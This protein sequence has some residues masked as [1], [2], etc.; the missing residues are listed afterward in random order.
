MRLLC[1][2]DTRG[3]PATG[4]SQGTSTY[5]TPVEKIR[6]SEY[7]LL[8]GLCPSMHTKERPNTDNF[9]KQHTSIMQEQL[10]SLSPP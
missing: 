1:A 5:P 8:E 9:Q 4:L 10:R 6:K 2:K 7:P 3:K